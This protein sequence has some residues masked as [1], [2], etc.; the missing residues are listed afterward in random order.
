MTCTYAEIIYDLHDGHPVMVGAEPLG[1][2]H[3]RT[4]DGGIYFLVG[5]TKVYLAPLMEGPTPKFVRYETQPFHSVSLASL[6]G[7]P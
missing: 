5:T 2:E 4:D 3:L 6:T 1:D 7:K